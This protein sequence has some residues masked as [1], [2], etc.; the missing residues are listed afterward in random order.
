MYGYS[1][2]DVEAAMTR[3]RATSAKGGP[4]TQMD[5]RCRAGRRRGL[6]AF[7]ARTAGYNAVDV[8]ALNNRKMS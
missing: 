8:V 5:A 2:G 7:R 6:L 3:T 1:A 4:R